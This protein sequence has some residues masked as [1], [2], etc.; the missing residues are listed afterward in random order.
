LPPGSESFASNRFHSGD[1]QPIPQAY[2]PELFH[3]IF[4]EVPYLHHQDRE[5]IRISAGKMFI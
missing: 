4:W 2:K 3:N 1:A 5:E